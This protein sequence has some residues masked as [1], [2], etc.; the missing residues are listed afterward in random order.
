MALVFSLN[1]SAATSTASISP[2]IAGSR[3]SS[4]H[5]RK[6]L[7]WGAVSSPLKNRIARR[8]VVSG[9]PPSAGSR[10]DDSSAS[11]EMSME[12]ALKLLGVSEGASFEDILR[13]KKSIL[14]SSKEDQEFVDKVFVF[15][16]VI[17]Y[18]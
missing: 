6:N 3:F 17:S 10:A 15:P 9:G 2:A 4:F 5:T 11:F 16:S 8:I 7:N 1:T 14:A 18:N 13:A 12:N